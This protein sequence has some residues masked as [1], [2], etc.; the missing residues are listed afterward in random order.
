NRYENYIRFP[1]KTAMHPAPPLPKLSY[2]PLQI[3]VIP[4]MNHHFKLYILLLLLPIIK[5]SH[6]QNIDPRFLQNR[7]SASWISV[8]GEQPSAYGVYLF[9]KQIELDTKPSSFI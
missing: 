8:P 6:A 9:R 4:A 5:D 7:W 1:V 2:F 3:N